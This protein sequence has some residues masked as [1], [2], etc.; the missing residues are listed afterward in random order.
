MEK[1]YCAP[2]AILTFSLGVLQSESFQQS[3]DPPL[4]A[5]KLDAIAGIGFATFLAISAEFES[6]FWSRDSVRF[7]GRAD[8]ERGHFV[9][10]ENYAETFASHPNILVFTLTGPQARALYTINHCRA[11][12]E[13]S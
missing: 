8:P 7:I 3:I 2:Y 4:P 13:K 5:W 6:N 12:L 1:T 10:I 9:L 11:Y